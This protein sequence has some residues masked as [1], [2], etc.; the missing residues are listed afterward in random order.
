MRNGRTSTNGVDDKVPDMTKTSHSGKTNGGM[1][2]VKADFGQTIMIPHPLD[3]SSMY[4]SEEEE[5]GRNLKGDVDNL[6]HSLDGA[7]VSRAV[8]T[9][10]DRGGR[11]DTTIKS[12]TR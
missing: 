12:A 6:A 10:P 11:K 7:K 4:G 5:C 1:Y 8:V 9:G 2:R 3:R